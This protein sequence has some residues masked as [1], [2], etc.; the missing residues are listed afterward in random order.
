[1]HHR[2]E[3]WISVLD[4]REFGEL[5]L[6]RLFDAG[7]LN[8]I[9]DLY[10]LKP[11]ELAALDRM[12][13]L[14][15]SKVLRSIDTPKTLSL[16]AFVAG[17]DFEGVG[18]TIMAKVTAFGFDT[19]E[20]LRA[21]RVEEL[22]GI[23]G[24]GSITAGTIVEGLAETREDMDAV[25]ASGIISIEAPLTEEQAPLRF[26]SFCFTGE[27]ARIKRSEAEERIKKLGGVAK[28]SVTKDLSFLVTNDP[29][30]GSSKNEKARK[31]GVRILDESEFLVLLANP[32]TATRTTEIAPIPES[33]LKATPSQESVVPPDSSPISLVSSSSSQGDLFDG[34][35]D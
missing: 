34:D 22:A 8:R 28:S 16:A 31:L 2:I 20:R 18:E 15:A 33:G 11:E 26:F 14:S 5:L 29:A 25:L 30:S 7:R 13:D 3:K 17:F 12:G 6:R 9:S 19:L 10:T 27:L 35:P 4:I 23:H 32:G 21:A 24:L 1:V